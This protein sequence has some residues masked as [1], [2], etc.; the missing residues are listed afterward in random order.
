MTNP[1]FLA[2]KR[3]WSYW[4]VDGLPQL[5]IGV[6]ALLFGVYMSVADTPS[7]S[8]GASVLSL[9]ALGIYLVLLVWGTQLLEWLKERI[10]YP[11][12]GYAASPYFAEKADLSCAPILGLPASQTS[13]GSAIDELKA[14]RVNRNRRLLLTYLLIA[15]G[16]VAMWLIHGSWICAVTGILTGLAL[17]AATRGDARLSGIVVL[18]FPL[19]GFCLGAWQIGARERINYFIF[20]AGFLFLLEGLVSLLIYLHRNPAVPEA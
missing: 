16:C 14:G 6:S 9:V 11:R 12:T 15:F 5:L 2:E 1:L 18:G 20:G 17:W 3:S 7:T 10:T 13:G 4:F 8:R 19:L